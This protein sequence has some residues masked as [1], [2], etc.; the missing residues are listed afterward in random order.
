MQ[1]EVVPTV[2]NSYTYKFPFLPISVPNVLILF[3]CIGLCFDHQILCAHYI[4]IQNH[5]KNLRKFIVEWASI[6]ISTWCVHTCIR[7]EKDGWW[8][9][10]LKLSKLMPG[11][12][13]EWKLLCVVK[14]YH[15]YKYVWDPSQNLFNHCWIFF[16]GMP[17][18]L[19]SVGQTPLY[20]TARCFASQCIGIE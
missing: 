9:C 19:S 17:N 16:R 8:S 13:D 12:E 11:S 15:V 1:C 6:S 14:G 18:F 4:H 10:R 7:T 2:L 5:K 3:E 20:R